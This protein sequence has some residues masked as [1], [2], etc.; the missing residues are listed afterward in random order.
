M[1]EWSDVCFLIS[2][3]MGSKRRSSD[4]ISLLVSIYGSKDIFINEY[5]DVLADRL[6]HQH[7]YNT[8]RSAFF[9]PVT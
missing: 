6:L 5:R 7:N 3:K 8:A 9:I 2:D 1:K 4:I